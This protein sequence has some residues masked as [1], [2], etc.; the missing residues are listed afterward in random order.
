MG[1]RNWEA[2]MMDYDGKRRYAQL[3]QIKYFYRCSKIKIW[4]GHAWE[5]EL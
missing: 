5:Y 2:Y 4:S 3:N 1:I